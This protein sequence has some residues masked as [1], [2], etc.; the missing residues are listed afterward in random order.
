MRPPFEKLAGL[1]LCSVFAACFVSACDDEGTTTSCEE[2][3]V[4]DEDEEVPSRDPDVQEWWD[5]AI[6]SHC[7][8]PPLGD[9]GAAGA[10][11]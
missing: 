4:A 7:A 5:R 1:A 11:N 3:P 10:Q 6:E 8:T 9:P 2:M